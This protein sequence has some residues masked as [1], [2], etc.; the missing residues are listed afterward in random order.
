MMPGGGQ[1]SD[2]HVMDEVVAA[3][4]YGTTRKVGVVKVG[5]DGV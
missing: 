1:S 4:A 3:R 5:R 2:S